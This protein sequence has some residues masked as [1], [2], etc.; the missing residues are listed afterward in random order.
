MTTIPS[1]NPIAHSRFAGNRLPDSYFQAQPSFV[2]ERVDQSA[3][4][5]ILGLGTKGLAELAQNSNPVQPAS[6][7][8]RRRGIFEALIHYFSGSR[9]PYRQAEYKPEIERFRL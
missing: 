8:S 2:P 6:T 5:F 9:K 4:D 1:G 3:E 7:R